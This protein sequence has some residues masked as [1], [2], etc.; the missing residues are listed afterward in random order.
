MGELAYTKESG[1]HQ[2]N[3]T[4]ETDPSAE[5]IT[6]CMGFF[7]AHFAHFFLDSERE[8]LYSPCPQK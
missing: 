8:S 7:I 2:G 5:R 1:F 6:F 4:V 3:S